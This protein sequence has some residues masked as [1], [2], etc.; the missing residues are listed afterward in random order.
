MNVSNISFGKIT[1]VSGKPSNIRYINDL[2]ENERKNGEVLMEDVTDY[3]RNSMSTGIISQEAKNGND[4]FLYVTGNDI[5]RIK[6]KA[7]NYRSIDGI[8]SSFNS[9]IN[10]KGYSIDFILKRIKE[11]K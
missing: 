1:I 2:I 6:S 7:P 11:D 4:V 5:N 3:Y 10:S 9:Y 8:I